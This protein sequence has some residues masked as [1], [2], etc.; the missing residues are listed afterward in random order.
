MNEYIFDVVNQTSK[1]DWA[2]AFQRTGAFPLDRSSLFSSFADAEAYAR[3]DKSDARELGGSSYVGQPVSVYDEE[4]NT[5]SLYIIDADRTLKEVG[6]GT[7]ASMTADDVS[8]T[9]VDGKVQLKDFG[10][11]YYAYV[12]AEYDEETGDI[13]T[14][15]D[16]KLTEGFKEGLEPK[17]RFEDG[18]Y[19]IAWYEPNP[20]VVENVVTV[21]ETLKSD[22]ATLESTTKT[23]QEQIGAPAEGEIAATGLYAQLEEKV[24]KTEVY[25]KTEVESLIAQADHLKRTTVAGIESIDLEAENA[26]Q[27]IYMVPNVETGNYDEYMVIDGEI[28]KVGDWKVDLSDYATLDDLDAKVDKVDNAR[29]IT[30]EEAEK[31]AALPST[32]EENFIKDTSDEFTVTDGKLEL[33]AVSQSKVT[34]LTS[35]LTSIEDVLNSKVTAQENARLITN[36]EAARLAAIKDLIQAVNPNHF[37]IDENGQLLLNKIQINQIEELSDKLAGKVD[38]VEGSRL[39]TE[40]EASKLEKL[41]IDQDGN[42]GL[43]G[44]VSAS[45]VQ[46]LYD[47]V[48]N[49][50]TGSG[51]GIYDD[52]SRPLLGIEA[53][54]EKNFISAVNSSQLSV[55]EN[56]ELSI[57]AISVSTVTGL[58]DILNAKATNT[59]VDSVVDLLNS[60]AAAYDSRLAALE[61]HL[62]WQS[63][64]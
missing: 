18:K 10:S 56:R 7:A 24:N 51:T 35:A 47:N 38:K 12:P 40:A 36:E 34:G 27:F 55:D 20:E 3:G 2:F 41:S 48:V 62:T 5:V 53:G 30:N 8:I 50:V 44:T 29:L 9:V 31:L 61:G 37:S 1:L 25:N 28:E 45:N 60:K 54:A 57:K 32:A 43:S 33:A 42:V 6:S 58:E 21:V 4:N 46:E 64:D 59:Y 49:I 16:Y 15:A 52:V 17:V 14:P 39:I 19:F 13:I 22:V 63:I 23:I 26:D 11:S